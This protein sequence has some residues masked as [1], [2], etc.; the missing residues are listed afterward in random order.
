MACHI[1]F[2]DVEERCTATGVRIRV[3]TDVAC[4][5]FLRRSPHRPWVHKRTRNV[6]GLILNDDFR[7]C[8]TVYSDY[9]QDE[10]G[11]TFEHT[12]YFTD[13]PVCTTFY[14]YFWGSV[15]GQV[16]VSNSPPFSYH[17]DGVNCL[18]SPDFPH[19]I[20]YMTPLPI[21]LGK[22]TSWTNRSV[23]GDVPLNTTGILMWLR[24][25]HLGGR[26]SFGVRKPSQTG[27]YGGQWYG[28]PSVSV[29]VGLNDA[30][31]FAYFA[32][33]SPGW[34]GYITGYTGPDV[35]YPDSV[36]DLKPPVA[37]TMHDV[38]IAAE[39]PDA[40]MIFTSLAATSGFRGY[41]LI[42][43]YGGSSGWY[44]GQY[45]YFPFCPVPT[46]G[47]VQTKVYQVTSSNPYWRAY[48]YINKAI[49]YAIDGVTLSGLV[50]GSWNTV[51]TNNFLWPANYAFIEVMGSTY[52]IEWAGRKPG[53]TIDLPGDLY[54]HNWGIFPLDD[55]YQFEL[56][57]DKDTFYGQQYAGSD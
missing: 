35:T 33:E 7:F 1:S 24:S 54:G 30:Y 56:Y 12:F 26:N 8:F 40:S 45:S 47:K 34:S 10:S 48:A 9:S 25:N 29:L 5:V 3:W 57:F 46:N 31:E 18:P 14:Y 11:D 16:C 22:A 19:I 23:A 6:R 52:S 2:R 41:H 53:E 21:T 39:W 28:N 17:N 20:N 50:A 4:T 49:P 51:L 36:I 44:G 42:R 55:A 38:D 13:W 37:N 43:P 32:S 15:D 27:V